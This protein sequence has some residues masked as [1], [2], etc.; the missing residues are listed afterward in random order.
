MEKRKSVLNQYNE[1]YMNIM[2]KAEN[3]NDVVGTFDHWQYQVRPAL[4]IK[5]GISETKYKRLSQD[6]YVV[7]IDKGA[8]DF[9]MTCINEDP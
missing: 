9:I 4:I 2:Q 7:L 5:L 6:L 1:A 3:L 8:G